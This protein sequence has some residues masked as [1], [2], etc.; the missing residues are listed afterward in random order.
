M[1][2]SCQT[3]VSKEAYLECVRIYAWSKGHSDPDLSSVT[4]YSTGVTYE[5]LYKAGGSRVTSIE[6]K[7]FAIIPLP[8]LGF[9]HIYSQGRQDRDHLC[10]QG[11]QKQIQF[12]KG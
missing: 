11:H 6:K 12:N 4:V 8:Y 7:I 2:G 9:Y 10:P 1:S 5:F 3:V